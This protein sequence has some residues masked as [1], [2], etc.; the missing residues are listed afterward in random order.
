MFCIACYCSCGSAVI[1]LIDSILYIHF[2]LIGFIKMP[3]SGYSTLINKG[4][5][6]NKNQIPQTKLEFLEAIA[7]I[8]SIL[9]DP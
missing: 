9:F 7:C 5:Y 2:P 4:I 3:L 8:T 1:Q 6:L